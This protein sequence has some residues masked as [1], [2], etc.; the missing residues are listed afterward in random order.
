[1]GLSMYTLV[2]G[3]VPRNSGYLLV[4]TVVPS[5]GVQTPSA[6]W[7]LSLAAPLRTV[8]LV[9]WLS[10]NIPLC[11]YQALAEPL[12]RQLYQ[13]PVS[14]HLLASTIVSGLGN[15]IWD[16]YPGGAVS[17]WSFLQSLLYT[18]SLYLLTG[19]FVLPFKKEQR[20][21]H[22]LDFLLL[23]FH[24]VCELYCIC[25]SSICVKKKVSHL[26]QFKLQHDKSASPEVD[27][28]IEIFVEDM[29]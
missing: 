11:I 23:N 10:E 20:Y 29:S 1:M 27:D 8:C 9:Q 25:K 14:K 24:A 28:R 15:C 2:G 7:D 17:R 12:R 18:L 5:M 22:T 16:G 19:Y 4:Q 3:L 26:H 6:P 13:A 21:I